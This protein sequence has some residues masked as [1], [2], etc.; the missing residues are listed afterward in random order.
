MGTHHHDVNL[1]VIHWLSVYIKPCQDLNLLLPS[2]LS[3]FFSLEPM[4]VDHDLLGVIEG[5]L[6]R[7]HVVEV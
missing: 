7:K 4:E 6:F 5:A 1:G 2:L 3:P